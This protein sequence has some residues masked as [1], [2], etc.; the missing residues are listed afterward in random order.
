MGHHEKSSQSPS[1]TD[2]DVDV[3]FAESQTYS[4][5]KKW[6]TKISA[7]GVEVRGITPVPVEERTDRRFINVFFVWF[8]MSMNLLPYV[9]PCW[10]YLFTRL[11]RRLASSPAWLELWPLVS[12]S[13]TA[14]C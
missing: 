14:R 11:I 2:V 8:T 3:S 12:V 1:T 4:T 6:L 13:E 9:C 10:S 5:P 7:L